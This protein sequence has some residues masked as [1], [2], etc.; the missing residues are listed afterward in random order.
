MTTFSRQ[1]NRDF[2]VLAVVHRCQDPMDLLVTEGGRWCWGACH[3]I[4]RPWASEGLRTFV[5]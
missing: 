3:H 4:A 1:D 5:L 2:P